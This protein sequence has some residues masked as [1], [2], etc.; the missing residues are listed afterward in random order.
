MATTKKVAK[1]APKDPVIDQTGP[2][3]PVRTRQPSVLA[4]QAGLAYLGLVCDVV[5][6]ATKVPGALPRTREDAARTARTGVDTAATTFRAGFDARIKDGRLATQH[7]L[8][9][10]EVK[11]VTTTFEPVVKQAKNTRT[12]VRAA[13]TSVTRTATKANEA[14]TEQAGTARTHVKGAVTSTGKSLSTFV[15]S[16][17]KG[18]DTAVESSRKQAGDTVSQVR[19]AVTSVT[20]I[21]DAALTAG[22]AQAGNARTQVKAAVTSTRKTVDATIDATRTLAG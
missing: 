16:G 8:E 14:A 4:R 3:A 17:R 19:G 1:K 7:L 18:L 20:N 10:P 11:R 22:R 13:V 6:R 9:R 5:T 12:Q 21:G 15:E 2:E